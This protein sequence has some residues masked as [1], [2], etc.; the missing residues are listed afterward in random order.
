MQ[1]SYIRAARS[2]GYLSL[3]IEDGTDVHRLTVSES[4]YARCGSPMQGDVIDGRAYDLFTFSDE[5]YR[6]TLTA[7]RILSFAD[8]SERSLMMKLVQKGISRE[9]AEGAV[10]EMVRLGY[11]NEREQLTRLV[12][13]EAAALRG[14]LRIVAKLSSKGP[15]QG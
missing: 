9:V 1:V 15:H 4:D 14:P 6:A 13:R 8:N 5:C 12:T 10:Q 7:L 3:G 11:V 2:R